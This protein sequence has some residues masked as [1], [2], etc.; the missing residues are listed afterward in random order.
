MAFP[1]ILDR[2]KLLSLIVY[3]LAAKNLFALIPAAYLADRM[4][5][6]P[7]IS[8]DVDEANTT[9]SETALKRPSPV[10][11]PSLTHANT[12][13]TIIFSGACVKPA[14]QHSAPT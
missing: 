1:H 2:I 12:P 5:V 4:D 6:V 8:V 3:L 11:Q 14:E 7:G 10:C 9:N 13:I